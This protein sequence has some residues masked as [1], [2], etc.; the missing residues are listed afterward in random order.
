[1]ATS[2]STA[3]PEPKTEPDTQDVLVIIGMW[4]DG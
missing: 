1:M 3:A 4:M 2:L